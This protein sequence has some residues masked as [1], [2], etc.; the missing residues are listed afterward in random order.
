MFSKLDEELHFGYQK[1][2]SLVVATNSDE[3]KVLHELKARGDKN[4][5]K[6]LEIIQKEKLFEL[7]PHLNPDCIAALR[8]PDA[9]NLIPY[10]FAVALME[11]AVD[12]GIELRIRRAGGGTLTIFSM[13]F[14]ASRSS[15]SSSRWR[16]FSKRIR[17]TSKKPLRI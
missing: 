5:V 2:G 6:N 8:S 10:E 13:N 3:E 1:N 17:T 12:N 14:S 15:T 9:G 11:N 4:G 7:E 16:C